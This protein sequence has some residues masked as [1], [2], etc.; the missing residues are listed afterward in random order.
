METIF[1]YSPPLFLVKINFKLI[2]TDDSG[3]WEEGKFAFSGGRFSIKIE[4]AENLE[5]S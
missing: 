3:Y 1:H 2:Y 4:W 5:T